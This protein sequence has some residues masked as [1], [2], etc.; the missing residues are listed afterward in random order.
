MLMAAIMI[1]IAEN[2]AL[3]KVIDNNPNEVEMSI[4]PMDEPNTI[5]T[6]KAEIFKTEETF[7]VP[8]KYFS[9]SCMAYNCIPGTVA[10]PIKPIIATK[11]SAG[12]L[13]G[14]NMNIKMNVIDN[15][16]KRTISVFAGFLLEN[17]PPKRFPKATA[18]P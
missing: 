15:K 9:E 2:T 18:I 3:I 17:F 5:P 6:L 13:L 10:K 16:A 1:A 8:V 7:S 12:I 14:R 4:L 11:I